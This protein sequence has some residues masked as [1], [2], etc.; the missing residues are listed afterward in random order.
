MRSYKTLIAQ[1]ELAPPEWQSPCTHSES[2]LHQL[3][4]YIGKLKSSIAHELISEYSQK[5]NLVADVFCGS[6]TVPLEAAQ[7]G[8]RVFAADASL[9]AVTLTK[10]K[11]AAPNG[12][13]SAY[14][15]LDRAL[16]AAK[17]VK[18]DLRSVPKWVRDFYH[19][20]T[21]KETLR[22]VT[23]LRG[24]RNHFLMACLLG[25][26][27]HQRPGFLSFPSS[28]LVPY[29]RSNKFPRE[30][31]PEM[32][33]YRDVEP[34]IRAK[35]ER[36]LKRYKGIDHKLVTGVRRSTIEMLTL[37]AEVDCFITSPPYMNALDYGRDNRLRNWFLS[38]DTQAGI[39]AQLS[40]AV[41]FRKVM[42]SYAQMLGNKLAKGGR[43]VF[44]VG[45]KTQRST[46]RFPSETLS[47]IIDE[48][49]PS[50]RIKEIISDQIPDIRRSRRNLAGVKMEHILIYEQSR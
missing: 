22:L 3:S 45:E 10:G 50:L 17:S 4:P 24:R 42:T 27:H 47:E 29:L 41:G 46:N 36:A 21:L 14:A 15:T 44:V 9:Y 30:D 23:V 12:L 40:G 43:C 2:T 34:R 28:H 32:Y 13:N 39:D 20:E 25:I 33:E 19:P 48:F 49:A 38:G 35:V 31:Y 18:V 26:S 7:M 5:G 1:P 6:G 16:V 8:R 11:L 37:P